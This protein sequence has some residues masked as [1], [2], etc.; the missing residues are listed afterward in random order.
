MSESKRESLIAIGVAMIII[1]III[2]FFA[3]SQPKVNTDTM[4]DGTMYSDCAVINQSQVPTDAT[5]EVSVKFPININTCTYEDL[6]AVEGIGESR[7][8]A[9][10]EYR[11][12]IGTFSTVEEV[13]N[14]EGIGEDIYNSIAPYLCV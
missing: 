1:G 8:N 11:N 10:I 14:I 4:S 9:I 2:I 6:L 7:A 5:E 3:L 12:S 13:K